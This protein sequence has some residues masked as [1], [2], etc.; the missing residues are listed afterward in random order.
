[1]NYG[2]TIGHSLE[3]LTNY[4][5]LLHGEAVSI[6]MVVAARISENLNLSTTD[7]TNNI[8]STLNLYGLPTKVPSNINIEELFQIAISEKN[9]EYIQNFIHPYFF[10]V[11]MQ[12][13][14][15]S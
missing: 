13:A 4:G 6:G 14:R 5:K 9:E 1:M 2:H 10:I 7:M 8:I 3:G 12:C 11:F 15:K